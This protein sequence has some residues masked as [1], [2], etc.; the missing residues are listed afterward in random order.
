MP[1]ITLIEHRPVVMRERKRGVQH[2]F[3]RELSGNV[4]PEY[5]SDVRPGFSAEP[6]TEGT[7]AERPFQRRRAVSQTDVG[8]MMQET[9]NSPA[10]SLA[11]DRLPKRGD[12]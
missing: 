9:L 10:R 3:R 12:F 4:L 2:H 11:L 6:A 7:V 1:S 8:G 5:L